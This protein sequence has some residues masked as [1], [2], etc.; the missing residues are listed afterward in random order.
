MPTENNNGPVSGYR[1]IVVNKSAKQ[2]IDKDNLLSYQ[3]AK[4][5]G[6]SNYITAE[7]GPKVALRNLT[8]LIGFIIFLFLRIFQTTLLLV[9]VKVMGAITMPLWIQI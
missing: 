3:E 8:F 7:L 1:I 2:G 4:H 9:M 5:I 6:L